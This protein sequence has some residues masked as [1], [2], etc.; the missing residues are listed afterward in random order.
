MS[1]IEQLLTR[2]R[3]NPAD[4]RFSDLQKVCE[5]YFDK[6]RMRGS[7]MIFKKLW[8]GSPPVLLQEVNGKA[9]AYQVRQVLAAIQKLED[10]EDV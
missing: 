2:M 1:T 8:R 4:V 3:N 9:K 7:H 5:H 6:P 10:G